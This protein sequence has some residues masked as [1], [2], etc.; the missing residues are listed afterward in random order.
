MISCE[1]K[2][3]LAIITGPRGVGKDSVISELGFRKIKGHT[4][5]SPRVGET[6]GV[7]YFFVNETS[8]LSMIKNDELVEHVSYPGASGHGLE[9]KGTSR[10]EIYPLVNGENCAWRIGPMAITKVRGIIE[11]NFNYAEANLILKNTLVFYIGTPNLWELSARL[12]KRSKGKI[13]RRERTRLI[14]RDWNMWKNHENL[15]DHVVI[16]QNL[17]ETACQIIGIINSYRPE[18]NL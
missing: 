13:D 17:S 18:K 12:S 2:G 5:R 6:E 16:N 7:D 10:S 1:K 11:S 8:F 9:Y 3:F 14:T 15:F 4:T